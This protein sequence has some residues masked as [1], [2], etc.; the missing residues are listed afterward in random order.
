VSYNQNLRLFLNLHE[1]SKNDVSTSTPPL[2]VYNKSKTRGFL[3][4]TIKSI[5]NSYKSDPTVMQDSSWPELCPKIKSSNASDILF[6]CHGNYVPNNPSASYLSLGGVDNSIA[7]F[8]NIF[9]DLDIS[10]YR[11]VVLGACESG[12]VKSELAD[13]YFGLPSAF[14]ASGVRYIV[15]SLWE[16]PEFTTSILLSKYFELLSEGNYSLPHA[17]N[18]AQRQVMAMTREKVLC[19]VKLNLP[20]SF[21]TLRPLIDNL[22]SVPFDHPYYWAGFYLSGDV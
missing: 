9:S 4:G 7:S 14:L 13:E 3:S 22:D 21:N 12:L 16:V 2:I 15:G 1:K 19:W 18:E 17:L 8:S 5:K 11:S 10:R 20:E 6:A